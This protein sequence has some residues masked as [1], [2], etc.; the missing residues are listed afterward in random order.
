VSAALS[1]VE[2]LLNGKVSFQSVTDYLLKNSKELK[3]LFERP[4]EIRGRFILMYGHAFGIDRS[5]FRSYVRFLSGGRV[6][7][8]GIYA[9]CLV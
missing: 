2:H 1:E 3:P 8:S 7:R 5:P 4:I 6:N 9:G